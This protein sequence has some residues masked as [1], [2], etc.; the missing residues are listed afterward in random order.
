MLIASIIKEMRLLSRDLH[1]VA[2]LFIMPILFM[3][4]MS[5][6][7]SNDNALSNRSEI[8]LLSEKNQL[9]DD[10]LAKLKQEN[11]AVKQAP[12][13]EL[14]QYQAELQAGKFD[15]LILN[16]NAFSVVFCFGCTRFLFLSSLSSLTSSKICLLSNRKTVGR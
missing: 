12:L 14:T 1:G 5:A 16:W 13:S 2:V 11:L 15:L 10:F 8:V 7:L 4:I 6:A 3:L 9:N